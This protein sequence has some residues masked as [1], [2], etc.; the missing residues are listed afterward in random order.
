MPANHKSQLK[1]R[2]LSNNS[3]ISKKDKA[4]TKKFPVSK[5]AKREKANDEAVNNS[6]DN[7]NSKK[8]RKLGTICSPT[9]R[10]ESFRIIAG[11]YERILYGIDAYWIKPEEE[12]FENENQKLKLEPIFI[13]PAH[14]G[15]IKTVAV[16]GRYLASGSSDELIKLYDLKKRKE[17]GSLWHHQGS[18]TSLQFYNETHML[19]GSEDGTVCIWRTKDWECLITKKGHKG[20]VNSLAIHPSGKIALSVSKDKTV[21]LWNLMTGRKATARGIGREGEIISWNTIGDQYAILIANVIE[22]YNVADAK[23]V[24]KFQQRS[25]FICMKYY[26]HSELGEL[27]ITGGEDK[28]INIYNTKDGTCMVTISGHQNRIKAIDIINFSPNENSC[29]QL[30]LLVSVSSDGVINVWNLEKALKSRAESS[31]DQDDEKKVLV[32]SPTFQTPLASYATKSR[33]T[34]L[35]LSDV[36]FIKSINDAHDSEENGGIL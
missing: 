33:L 26:S 12:G 13:F 29:T 23:I 1:K 5:K 14:S 7:D 32:Q 3:I 16:G 18:I 15:C 31:K 36:H 19:S 24:H 27:L 22:I 2:K 8:T 10:R 20:R 21:G 17:Y 6:I 30:P 34:C 11:S 25:R 35:V 28:I 9:L 4:Q